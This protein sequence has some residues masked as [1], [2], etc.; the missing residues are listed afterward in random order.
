MYQL[1]Q[2][3]A[4]YGVEKLKKESVDLSNEAGQVKSADADYARPDGMKK[5]GY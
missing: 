5:V 4:F 1:L 2:K 3:E